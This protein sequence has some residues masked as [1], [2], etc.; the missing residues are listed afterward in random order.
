MIAKGCKSEDF[1]NLD[2]ITELDIASYY[3]GIRTLPCLIHSPLRQDN[4]PSFALYCPS[5]NEVNYKDFSTGECGKIWTLLTKMWDCSYTDVRKRIFNDLHQRKSVDIQSNS[6]F[7]S[8]NKVRINKTSELKCKTRDWMNYDIE[9][10]ESYGI[11]A[12]WLKYANVYPVSH[13]IIIKDNISHIFVADKYTYAFVEFKEGKTTIKL[14]SPFNKKGYKWSSGHDKS[15]ISLWNKIPEKGDNLFITSSLKDS[16]NLWANIG[17]PA[18]SPQ[19]EGYSF[20]PKVIEDLKQRFK[21]IIVFYD[22]DKTGRTDSK[23]LVE[24]F[25]LKEIFIPLEYNAKDPSDLYKVYGKE[26]YLE[27]IN[28]L[29]KHLI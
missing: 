23:L 13:K 16:L 12:K 11:S 27:T 5:L 28:T 25:N 7:L 18:I 29:L 3:L 21:N 10:W 15:V 22:N 2:N 26:K 17:I 1:I 24:K 9:Y 4:N 20:N 19:G 6:N 14:Y 8:R